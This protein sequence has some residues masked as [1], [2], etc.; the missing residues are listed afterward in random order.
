MCIFLTIMN[1]LLMKLLRYLDVI[2]NIDNR[3]FE[4]MV[5]SEISDFSLIHDVLPI[6][7][8]PFL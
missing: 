2:Q 1:M 8:P 5:S 7:K 6:L 4:Y 3:Y